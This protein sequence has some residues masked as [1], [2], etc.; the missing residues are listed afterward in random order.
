M[1]ERFSDGS[2]VIE[3][4]IQSRGLPE[5]HR[6]TPVADFS[7]QIEIHRIHRQIVLH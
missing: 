3:A 4:V 2:R 6:T 5:E 1:G 7:A